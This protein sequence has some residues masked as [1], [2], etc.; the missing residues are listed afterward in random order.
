MDNTGLAVRALAVITMALLFTVVAGTQFA[1]AQIQS[2]NQNSYQFQT[3]T[4]DNLKNNPMVEKILSEIE[5]SKKQI[6]ELQKKQK[7]IEL[8]KKLI[9]QQRLIAAQLEKQ[10]LQIMELNNTAHTPKVAFGSFVSTI[11]NTKVQ[12][13][14]W[15]EFNFMSQRVD[16][17]HT[18][19]KKILDNGGTWKEAMQEFYKYAAIKHAELIEINKNLNVKYGLADPNVQNNFN[20]NGML[21]DNYIKVPL[22]TYSHV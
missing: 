8:N 21:P 18:A 16:A 20:V 10:A 13:V 6:A 7:D 14:Y 2:G 5:Y 11:N 1:A 4:G 15:E 9:D 12:N 17:G 22:S 19:M 3:I